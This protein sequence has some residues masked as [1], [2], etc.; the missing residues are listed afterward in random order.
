MKLNILGVSPQKIHLFFTHEYKRLHVFVFFIEIKDNEAKGKVKKTAG[1]CLKSI[2]FLLL[3]RRE[4]EKIK[5]YCMF[6][7]ISYKI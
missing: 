4:N 6:I 1:I 3:Y 7:F 2:N 5:T